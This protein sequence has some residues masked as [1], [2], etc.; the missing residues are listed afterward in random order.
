MAELYRLYLIR[1]RGS[2]YKTQLK[3]GIA[4]ARSHSP[5]RKVIEVLLL[6]GFSEAIHAFANGQLQFRLIDVRLL[7]VVLVST[8]FG[9]SYGILAAVLSAT[10]LALANITGGTDWQLL[11]YNTERWIP[12]VAYIFVATVCGFIQTKNKDDN[13]ALEKENGVLKEQNNFLQQAYTNIIHDKQQLKRQII[14]SR[15]GS[16]KLF[17]IFKDLDKLGTDEV[18]VSAVKTLKDQLET[19]KVGIYF[20]EGHRLLADLAPALAQGSELSQQVDLMDFP[21]IAKTLKEKGI[22]ANK[23][24]AEAYPA[25]ALGIYMENRL[26]YMIWVEDVP[27]SRMNLYHTN[28]LRMVGEL[29]ESALVKAYYYQA[30]TDQEEEQRQNLENTIID[31]ETRRID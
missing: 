13:T 17:A 6:F 27:Y 11:F 25:Y 10:A 3:E 20:F 5:L 29:T 24:L 15:D 9:A 23:E 8:V 14:G 30:Y 28:L 26:S 21:K 12:F 19:D 16:S 31:F 4:K 18:L 7:F 2:Q 1:R 22:W